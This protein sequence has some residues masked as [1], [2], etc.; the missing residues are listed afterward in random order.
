MQDTVSLDFVFEDQGELDEAVATVRGRRVDA[1][2]ISVGINDLGFSSL[3]QRSILKASGQARKDRIAGVANRVETDLADGLDAL[4]AAIDARLHPRR[5]FLTEYPVGIFKE[6]A[7]GAEP[8]GVLGS[9]VPSPG[10]QEGFD[11]DREDA[12]DMGVVGVALNRKLRA[13]AHDFGWVFVSGIERASDGHGY[14]SDRPYFVSAE[15]SCRNQG[16]F[17]GMLH[18]NQRG[19]RAAG[20]CIAR[21]LRDKLIAPQRQWLEPVLHTVMN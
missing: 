17:E 19:H 20:D 3:V 14:C 1:V 5:V 13:K 15:E 4:R 6:I 10:S 11:L 8:C 7:E 21:A 12:R 2:V 9:I 16:D 18:P